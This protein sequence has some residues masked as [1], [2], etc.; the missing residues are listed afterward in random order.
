MIV[1]PHLKHASTC[2]NRYTKHNIDN[3]E[4]VQHRAAR[5]VLNLY[6]Y[7]PTA[8][9]SDKIKKSLQWDSLQH[10]RAVAD[11]CMFYK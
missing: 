4:V 2:W 3:L 6:D 9:L 10:C 5:F 8:D 11:V 7:C 1:C